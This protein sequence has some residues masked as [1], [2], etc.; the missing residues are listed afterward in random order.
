MDP[1]LLNTQLVFNGI[2]VGCIYGLV[3]LGFVLI[4]KATEVVN[5]AQGELLM[6]GAFFAYTYIGI[7]G[8]PYWLGALLAVASMAVLGGLLDSVVMRP[9]VGQPT[10]A[11]VMLTIGLGII[12]RAVVT[13]IPGWGVE[14]YSID[15]PYANAV[16]KVAGLVISVDYF[17]IVITTCVLV[18]V[19]Y[20]FFSFTRFGVAMQASS[21]NQL[22]AYYM[23]IP[24]KRVFS[25]I[26]GISAS[27]AAIAGILLA[28]VDLIDSSMGFIGL[29]AFPAAVLGGFGSIPGALVGG[30][31]IGVIESLSG[32]YL[33]PGFKDVAAFIVLLVVLIVRPEGLFGV[34]TK[35][36]V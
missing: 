24:V 19:L 23:G 16:I 33:P 21:Q 29:K 18:A 5:F 27:V 4:Y 13:M 12:I 31:I 22:A 35:K 32:F 17:V 8:M 10:F 11:Y 1:I 36:R 6:L 7:L 30:V 25:M 15:T 3:A 2:A 9:V 28:P 34:S 14:T 20:G 26:W